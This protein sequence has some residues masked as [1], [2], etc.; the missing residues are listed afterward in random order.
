MTEDK[1]EDK[2]EKDEERDKKRKK[3]QKEKTGQIPS[4]L[5]QEGTCGVRY[6]QYDED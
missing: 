6:R 4:D 5:S 2:D 1:D 3:R